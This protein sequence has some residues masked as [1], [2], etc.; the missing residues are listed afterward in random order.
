[1]TERNADSSYSLCLYS[2]S[3]KEFSGNSFLGWRN[4]PLR[5]H[6]IC[7]ENEVCKSGVYGSTKSQLKI[8]SEHEPYFLKKL[9]LSISILTKLDALSQKTLKQEFNRSNTI[10]SV[11]WNTDR[12]IQIHSSVFVGGNAGRVE[13]GFYKFF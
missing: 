10:Y 13:C 11:L 8:S 3:V 1:M 2:L 7:M 6:N 4:Q 9:R 12:H 5:I